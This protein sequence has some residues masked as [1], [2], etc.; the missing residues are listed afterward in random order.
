MSQNPLAVLQAALQTERPALVTMFK[1][2]VEAI[3]DREHS[4]DPELARG[5]VGVIAVLAT[6]VYDLRRTVR[7]MEEAN[8]HVHLALRGL[9]KQVAAS[10]EVARLGMAGEL[11]VAYSPADILAE[12]K[13]KLAV[14]AENAED[15]D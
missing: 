13:V 6:E 4:L 15:Q 12:V 3:I 5:M 11:P 1:G 10:H 9:G 2:Q 14:A 8:H 7:A